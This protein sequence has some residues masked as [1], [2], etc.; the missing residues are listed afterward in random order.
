MTMKISIAIKHDDASLH[1]LYQHLSA[2]PKHRGKRY[3]ARLVSQA[4]EV[5][6]SFLF[7]EGRAPD[8]ALVLAYQAD[9][10]GAHSGPVDAHEA[11]D[12]IRVAVVI[13][14]GPET[15]PLLTRLQGLP[16]GKGQ[17]VR[18]RLVSQVLRAGV[19]VLYL[20]ASQPVLQHGAATPSLPASS[21]S[22]A[23]SGGLPDGMTDFVD[24]L[25]MEGL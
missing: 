8:A 21:S 6:A 23:P 9:I 3:R 15:E 11:V 5:G 25:S 22:P 20:G 13:Q 4:I 24:E 16:D 7:S 17:Q 10:A 19:R 12:V 2:L 14:P 1:P 18:S